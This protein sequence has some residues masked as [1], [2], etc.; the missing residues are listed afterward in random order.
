LGCLEIVLAMLLTV[1]RFFRGSS[2]STTTD[3][4]SKVGRTSIL[5]LLVADIDDGGSGNN[6][7]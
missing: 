6:N 5:G 4:I 2:P 1:E 3:L 7:K